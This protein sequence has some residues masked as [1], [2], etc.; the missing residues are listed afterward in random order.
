[1][2]QVFELSGYHR[3]QLKPLYDVILRLFIC[4]LFFAGMFFLLYELNVLSGVL[5]GLSFVVW[6]I[7]L[8]FQRSTG[9]V[10]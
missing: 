6:L 10:P 1:M 2:M 4:C 3:G 5:L 9:I 7:T 8:P